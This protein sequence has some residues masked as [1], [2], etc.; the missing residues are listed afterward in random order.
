M[1]VSITGSYLQDLVE[2]YPV[3][4]LDYPP[5]CQADAVIEEVP[6]QH[7]GD[8]PLLPL[9]E[10]PKVCTVVPMPMVMV[11]LVHGL[12]LPPLIT[13]LSCWNSMPGAASEVPAATNSYV[14]CQIPLIWCERYYVRFTTH[15]VIAL[16]SLYDIQAKSWSN[17]V[18]LSKVAPALSNMLS[19]ILPF[20]DVL[21]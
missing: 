7:K 14:T 11:P 20:W 17:C 15:D 6:L 18:H 2:S 9:P 12:L 21:R 1:R 19:L 4:L 10:D 3:L 13:G 5:A 16:E 8:H